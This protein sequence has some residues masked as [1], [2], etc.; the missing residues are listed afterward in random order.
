MFKN[1]IYANLKGVILKKIIS[2]FV[3][4]LFTGSVYSQTI[5]PVHTYT[6]RDGYNGSYYTSDIFFD[7]SKFELIP[8]LEKIAVKFQKERF[9]IIKDKNG[10][11]G[12]ED[13]W[14][15]AKKS[16]GREVFFRVSCHTKTDLSYNSTGKLLCLS[17]TYE[18][19]DEKQLS[20]ELLASLDKYVPKF[21][22][23]CTLICEEF[24]I[25]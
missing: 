5:K 11:Y 8:L 20:D 18:D 9:N 22:K 1:I 24:L 25:K 10:S 7:N 14:I 17:I 21:L 3:I 4:C 6:H 16:T 12:L 13:G 2:L 15:I 23:E 19:L